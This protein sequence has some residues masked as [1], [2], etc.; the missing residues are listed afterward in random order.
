MVL[1]LIFGCEYGEYVVFCCECDC[2]MEI[3]N[4]YWVGLEGVVKNYG[5]DDVFL[6]GDIDEI[7]LG[8]LEGLE[9][10]Y[11]VMGCD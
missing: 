6:I 9:C 8:L 1:V 5:V 4:G 7:L 10:V 3:W 11:Y 2:E